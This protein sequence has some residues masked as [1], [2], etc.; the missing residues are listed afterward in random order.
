MSHL[1]RATK[2]P[3]IEVR[4]AN[5]LLSQRGVKIENFPKDVEDGILLIILYEVITSKKAPKHASTPKTEFQKLENLTIALTLFREE[6]I[7][8]DIA[9]EEVLRGNVK[10]ILGFLWSL[11]CKYQLG[12]LS[13]TSADMTPLLNDEL[14][15]YPEGKMLANV[16]GK[17]K[18]DLSDGIIISILVD[19]RIPN[20]IDVAG[21]NP[22][23]PLEN[24]T[25]AM[26]IAER[27]LKIPKILVPEEITKREVE[28]Q[29]LL[30]YLS[31][32]FKI[33]TI[34]KPIPVAPKQALKKSVSFV[35][36]DIDLKPPSS[37]ETS[38]IPSDV[39]RPESPPLRSAS[40]PPILVTPTKIPTRLPLLFSPPP[41]TTSPS[42]RSRIVPTDPTDLPT[43]PTSAFKPIPKKEEIE[44]PKSFQVEK[45]EE[46]V[47]VEDVQVEDFQ[48]EELQVEM[49][50]KLTDDLLMRELI[51]ARATIKRLQDKINE[52]AMEYHDREKEWNMS[53]DDYEHQIAELNAQI[54][55]IEYRAQDPVDN[56]PSADAVIMG[57]ERDV[58]IQRR[59]IIELENATN[60][61]T[62]KLKATQDSYERDILKLEEIRLEKQIL[63]SQ[64]EKATTELNER[65]S[66][67]V[68]LKNTLAKLIEDFKKKQLEED[69]FSMKTEKGSL[70]VKQLL[71]K[72]REVSK[73]KEKAEKQY[74]QTQEKLEKVQA[75]KNDEVKKL[76]QKLQLE[77]SKLVDKKSKLKQLKSELE[78]ERKKTLQAEGSLK[79]EQRKLEKA[80]SKDDLGMMM[81]LDQAQASVKDLSIQ[82][83]KEKGESAKLRQR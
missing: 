47:Q 11:I 49:G 19:N 24:L 63:N 60:E 23:A 7:K 40:P 74:K 54:E 59:R 28:D 34:R 64:V 82:L 35:P 73:E 17:L 76:K 53:R 8:L 72:L 27:D 69:E 52:D 46:P 51:I 50:G 32:F 3:N 21:L 30:T 20:S 66:E 45:V 36:G 12:K 61:I 79:K 41:T 1:G 39:T 31:Y 57:L 5:G 22:S 42:V 29:F 38:P 71:Q 26:D 4:W 2:R 10:L 58:E 16:T 14:T 9:A 43:T 44:E 75:A 78:A 48:V 83:E 77:N 33:P 80:A 56:P 6:Q 67:S 70:S 62:F 65:D 81:Q 68:E 55:D 25:N 15:C 18:D 13:T 37:R